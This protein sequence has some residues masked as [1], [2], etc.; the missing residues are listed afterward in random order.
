MGSEP[1]GLRGLAVQACLCSDALQE[2]RRAVTAEQEQERK[3][4]REERNVR[5][6]CVLCFARRD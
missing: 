5:P 4:Q 6:D 3:K 1:P 2:A